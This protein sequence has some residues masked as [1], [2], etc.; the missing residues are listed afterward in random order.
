MM[1]RRYSGP[2]GSQIHARVRDGGTQ[3]L[4]CLHP[5]PHSGAW[6]ETLARS[7][8][9]DIRV[10][11]PDY[12]GYG[13]SDERPGE[14]SIEAYAGAMLG[15]MDELGIEKASLLGFHTGC[16]VAAELALLSPSRIEN[17]VLIDVPCFDAET[18]RRFSAGLA[19]GPAIPEF[20]DLEAAWTKLVAS[21]P[22]TASRSR[23][24]ALFA[25]QMRSH[26]DADAAFRAAFGHDCETRLAAMTHPVCVIATKSM[27]YEA[28]LN[29]ASIIPGARLEQRQDIT[30]PALET[31]AP[32]LAELI[33]D[34]LETELT[35]NQ[36][37]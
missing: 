19:S 25:E 26:P 14:I 27:L 32:E 20:S 8:P 37:A 1:Y 31:A 16:L 36:D 15:M 28:S 6:F 35:R 12:P 30:A 3:T 29:A 2:P 33:C 22:D 23:G 10:I 21:R 5:A 17:L 34:F 24:I 4:I 9:A 18:R 11:A 7:I 13:A